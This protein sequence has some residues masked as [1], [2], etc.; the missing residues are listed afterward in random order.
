MHLFSFGHK[1]YVKTTL[2]FSLITE[3]NVF[4][5]ASCEALSYASRVSISLL[6]IRVFMNYK[7]SRENVL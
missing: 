5:F 3:G 4:S 6:F 2:K 7:I 1:A